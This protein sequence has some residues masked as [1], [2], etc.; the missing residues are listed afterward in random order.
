M[1]PLPNH[2]SRDFQGS[3][4]TWGH[5][6]VLTQLYKS[7]VFF[8]K[9]LLFSPMFHHVSTLTSR[10]DEPRL[11]RRVLGRPSTEA[12]QQ[13]E[14]VLSLGKPWWAM[15]HGWKAPDHGDHQEMLVF[16]LNG[17]TGSEA[18]YEDWSMKRHETRTSHSDLDVIYDGSVCKH[19][20]IWF[21]P[22][23]A[24]A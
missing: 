22:Q 8:H 15:D 18:T 17:F 23:P 10:A 1:I 3:V 4:T 9:T 24:L 16:F 11:P 6:P 21:K 7:H 13:I 19:M 14:H 5:E 20:D 12:L 2:D